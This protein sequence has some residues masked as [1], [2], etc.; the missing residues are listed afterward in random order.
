MVGKTPAAGLK[1]IETLI[2]AI[3]MEAPTLRLG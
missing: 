2:D 1:A 3:R